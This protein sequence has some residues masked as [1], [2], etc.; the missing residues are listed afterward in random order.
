MMVEHYLFQKLNL[1][2][3]DKSALI[4]TETVGMVIVADINKLHYNLKRDGY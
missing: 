1:V 2:N 3:L 4:I